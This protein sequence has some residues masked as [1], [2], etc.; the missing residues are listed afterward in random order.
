MEFKD[1]LIN[2]VKYITKS[3]LASLIISIVGYCLLTKTFPPDLSR[4]KNLY[5]SYRK[6]SALSVEIRHNQDLRSKQNPVPQDSETEVKELEK[7]VEHRKQMLEL[8]SQFNL[9]Q[10][11]QKSVANSGLNSELNSEISEF[12]PNAVVL[13]KESYNNL[14]LQ[15]K[16]LNKENQELRLKLAQIPR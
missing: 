8:L 14:R 16:E 13:S 4:L 3:I 2:L 6:L 9:M 5:S 10:P 11:V 7:L 1:Y 15:I 12:S